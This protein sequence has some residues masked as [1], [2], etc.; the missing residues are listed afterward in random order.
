MHFSM[1]RMSLFAQLGSRYVYTADLG[2]TLDITWFIRE[3]GIPLYNAVEIP[4]R[5]LLLLR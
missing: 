4:Q 1:I 5:S 3:L 2:I